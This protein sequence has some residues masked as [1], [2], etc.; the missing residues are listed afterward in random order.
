[1]EKKK[2]KPTINPVLPLQEMQFSGHTLNFMNN[3]PGMAYRCLF[4]ADWTML[5]LSQGCKEITGYSGKELLAKGTFAFTTLIEPLDRDHVFKTISEAV[6]QNRQ[7]QLEYRMIHR[8][9]STH[10]VWEQGHAI[11]GEQS[12]PLYLDGYIVDI[13][14]RKKMEQEMKNAAN[15][16][17]K[18]NATKD[19]FF[20]LVAHDLQN[21][22]YAIISLSEFLENNLDS[23][24]SQ[25]L[26]SFINQI[27][28]SAKGIYALLENLLDWAR[29]QT[30]KI[31]I[32]RDYVS[33]P[34]LINFLIDYFKPTTQEKK[35]EI[36]FNFTDELMVESD[37]RLLTSILRNLISNAIKYSHPN[38]RV[39]IQLKANEEQ[40][41]I[42]VTDRGTGI[43][44]RNLERIFRIDNELRA[45]GTN[46]EEGSGLGLILVKTFAD[47]IGGKVYAISKLNQGSTFTLILPNR[48]PQ[49]WIDKPD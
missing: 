4:D 46:H 44:R 10:W 26:L 31:T 38:S 48:K 37:S 25:E 2:P 41:E 45:L 16:L 34:R 11:Y 49:D 21:P 40:I 22:V 29:S 43:S 42:S 3:L 8:D 35:I 28:V 30:G 32:Q 20:S 23:F 17:V 7:Y 12:N 14:S 47:L 36:A 13:T 1:M 39:T 15:H 9:G 33:L 27:N 5:F 24:S 6:K 19:K 18:L